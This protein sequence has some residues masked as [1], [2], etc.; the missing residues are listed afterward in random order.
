MKKFI[1]YIFIGVNILCM[2]LGLFLVYSATIGFESPVIKEENEIVKLEKVRAERDENPIIYTMDPFTVNLD[3][4]PKRIIQTEV[5]LVLLDKAGFEHIIHMGSK[6]RDTIVRI[7][8]SKSFSEIESVQ[9]KLFLKDQIAS[10]LN[11]IMV[12]GVIKDVYFSEF[13]VK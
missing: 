2:S 6:A 10:Q 7:L 12:Q 5:N 11:D 8:N 4:Y 9:G 13:I 1:P 3:G